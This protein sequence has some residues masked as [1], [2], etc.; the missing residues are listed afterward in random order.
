MGTSEQRHRGT[1]LVTGASAGI[2]RELAR[3]FASHG[4]DLALA[5][6]RRDALEAL[7]VELRAEHGRTVRVLPCDLLEPDAVPGLFAALEGAGEPVEVLVNNAGAIEMGA[8]ADTG[9]D[10]LDRLV[11]LNV[12]AVTALARTFLTPML[13]RGRGR[14]LNVASVASFQPIPSMAVYAATKAY[15]LSL[16]EALS[17]ELSGTGVTV[18]ALCPG[19]TVTDMVSKV[20]DTNEY[21]S[22]IPELLM[23]DAG[24]VAAAGYAACMAGRV[25]E[26]P[27]LGNAALTHWSRFQ[28]RWLVRGLGGLVGRRF[29][30]RR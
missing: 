7:A 3:V 19:L 10:A 30:A 11:E 17:E 15:V 2:G 21:A 25:I 23:S 1:A 28:P 13:G 6:R 16:T 8:F 5:A 20:R 12:R 27:G 18:T 22:W 9:T 24:D 26:V 4:W 14:I 29:L